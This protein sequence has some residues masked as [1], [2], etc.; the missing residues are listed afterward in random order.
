MLAAIA[1]QLEGGDALKNH[2]DP[3][4][5]GPFEYAPFAGGFELHS[6]FKDDDKPLALTVGVRGK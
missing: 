1:V 6:N 2:P 4:V 3:V 5:G